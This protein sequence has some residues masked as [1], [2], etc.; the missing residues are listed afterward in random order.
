MLQ[1]MG[2]KRPSNGEATNFV[3][4]SNGDSYLVIYK[5]DRYELSG[6]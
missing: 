3:L 5:N 2:A 1:I 6:I 4:I